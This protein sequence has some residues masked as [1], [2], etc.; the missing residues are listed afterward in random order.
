M[1]YITNSLKMNRLTG[2]TTSSKNLIVIG[3]NNS[4][5][6]IASEVINALL[7]DGLKEEIGYHLIRS[8]LNSQINA[9]KFTKLLGWYRDSEDWSQNTINS[10]DLFLKATSDKLNAAVIAEQIPSSTFVL[11]LSL[12]NNIAYVLPKTITMQPVEEIV[13]I[14]TPRLK[15]LYYFKI[16]MPEFNADETEQAKINDY[17]VKA[18]PSKLDLKFGLLQPESLSLSSIPNIISSI[19][20]DSLSFT[21]N[22]L[23]LLVTIDSLE[24]KEFEGLLNQGISI[25][26]NLS[27]RTLGFEDIT[28]QTIPC[29][30]RLD[31]SLIKRICLDRDIE[32][33]IDFNGS[34]M[35]K[36]FEKTNENELLIKYSAEPEKS[37]QLKNNTLRYKV[38]FDTSRDLDNNEIISFQY[39][40]KQN[41][42]FLGPWKNSTIP[43]VLIKEIQ[44]LK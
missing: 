40:L 15:T 42:T 3:T 23:I 34:V 4:R 13:V 2:K 10:I 36:L 37:V 32:I 19:C 31:H 26:Y 12:W 17:L 44:Q 35:N 18:I 39:R 16:K 6:V 41:R 24:K 5:L 29:Y 21:N 7:L 33:N 27:L 25:D 30:L 1:D 20:F 28:K 11:F 43:F 9:I 38:T 14:E 22:Q 8:D